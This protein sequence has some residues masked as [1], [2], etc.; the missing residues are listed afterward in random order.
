ML[1]MD[2]RKE[3]I[4]AAGLNLQYDSETITQEILNCKQ[5]WHYSPPYK[6]QLD[7]EKSKEF[8]LA[9]DDDYDKMD[10]S[11]SPLDTT[12]VTK[13]GGGANIFYLR[14]NSVSD[15]QSFSTT[16]Y[17]P[18]DIWSWK[19]ELDIPYTK[20]FIESLPFTKLG[21]IRCFIFN[22]SFLPVHKDYRTPTEYGH[23]EEFDK[24]LGLSI[25]PSTGGVPMRIWSA[26]L[27]KVVSVP[28]NAMLFNDSVFHGVPKTTGY[29][30]TLRV[31][32]EIDYNYFSDKVDPSCI[33]YL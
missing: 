3:K 16:K 22:D 15:V 26:A 1:R 5:Y 6:Y 28:G 8:A 31:F 20:Q 21:M 11:L 2:L 30:I 4:L 33:Y 10:Y 7:H 9:S 18:H 12:R 14:K 32:G 19:E 24:C 13:Q 25:I 23:S 17:L 29:R 27:G